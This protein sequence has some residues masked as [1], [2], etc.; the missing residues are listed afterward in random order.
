MEFEQ[1]LHM[2][3]T[4]SSTGQFLI[5]NNLNYQKKQKLA[6]PEKMQ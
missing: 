2:A 5:K 3:A 4:N 1:N 6:F